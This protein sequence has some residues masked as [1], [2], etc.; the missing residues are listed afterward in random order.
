M[1]YE[2]ALLYLATSYEVLKGFDKAGHF[3]ATSYE[4]LK[5]FDKAG[6]LY[7]LLLENSHRLGRNL[8]VCGALTGL[9]RVKYAQL[10]FAAIPPLFAQAEQL[11]QQYEY[12]DYLSSLY[13]IRGHIT[14]DGFIHAWDGSTWPEPRE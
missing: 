9:V 2:P 13:L 3:Y 8:F 12:N 5:G 10:D 14:W 4:V 7:Q 6:H 1:N 11:A